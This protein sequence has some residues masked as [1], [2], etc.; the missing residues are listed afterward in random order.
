M[1]EVLIATLGTESQVVTLS[2]LELERQGFDVRDVVIVRTSG[3]VSSIQ[4][5]LSRLDEAFDH[6][7]RLKKYRYRH[8]LIQGDRGPIT[9]ITTQAEAEHTFNSLFQVVRRYKLNGYRIH[10]NVAGGRKPM[11]IYGMVTAQILFDDGDRLWHLVSG[12][13]LVKSRRLFPEGAD[14]Y[15]LVPIPV[16]RWTDRSPLETGVAHANSPQEALQEQELQRRDLRLQLFLR[17]ELTP[18]ERAIA[19]LLA[20]GLSNSDIALHRQVKKNTVEKQIS[21]IYDKWRAYWDLPP[22]SQPRRQIV[23]ELS[24]YLA[25]QPKSDR[26]KLP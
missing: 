11:S 23:A 26:S 2:L 24:A 15:S 5:S 12:D 21:Q 9:D 18:D 13:N 14:E 6:D 17:G 16:I 20:A 8:E 4:E 7:E 10:L 22:T 1:R 25:R 3:A 19:H